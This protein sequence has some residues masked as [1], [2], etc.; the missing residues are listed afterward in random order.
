MKNYDVTYH[1]YWDK[2]KECHVV[3]ATTTYAGRTINGF[4]YT[5]PD[6]TPIDSIGE[7]LAK[8][9][10]Y[11]KVLDKKARRHI[12]KSDE[13]NRLIVCYLDEISN[14][15]KKIAQYNSIA[16]EAIADKNKISMEI[17]ELLRKI[18]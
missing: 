8:L 11:E 2:K 4:A 15:Q 13:L 1:K 9:R 5:H 14:L 12:N 7:E 18:G 10:C 17:Q 16:A 3:K 6:D